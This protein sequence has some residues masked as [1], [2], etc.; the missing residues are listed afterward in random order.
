VQ[1]E[2]YDKNDVDGD[3]LSIFNGNELVAAHVGLEKTVKS[4]TIHIDRTQ[5]T[6]IIVFAETEGTM[7]PNTACIILRDGKNQTEIMLK[8]DMVSSDS[9]ILNYAGTE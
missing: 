7:P 8:S 2:V 5:S 9:V 1:I 6:Q 3:T 4:F